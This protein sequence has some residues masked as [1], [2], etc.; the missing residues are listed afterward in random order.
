MPPDEQAIQVEPGKII[1]YLRRYV[2]SCET[3]AC[4]REVR[5]SFR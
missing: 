5:H 1:L 3:R 2:R 4:K